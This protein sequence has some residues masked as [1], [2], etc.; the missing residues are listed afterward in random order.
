[1]GRRATLLPQYPL[2]LIPAL[3]T[4]A[5]EDSVAAYGEI[6]RQGGGGEHRDT[7]C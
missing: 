2:A 1:M 4:T 5:A 3:T 6:V 7:E